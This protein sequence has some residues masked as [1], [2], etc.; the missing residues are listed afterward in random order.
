[1]G[2]NETCV[3]D[4]RHRFVMSYL[5]GQEA[6]SGL[7]DLFGISRPT[8]Y[9]WVERFRHE[10]LSGLLDR[11]S[12][13]LAHGRRTADALRD[14]IVAERHAHPHWGPKKIIG[15][16]CDRQPDVDWP[17]PSTAG[18]ILK[19]EGLV[20][21][22]R[23]RLRVPPR[24][25]ALTVPAHANHVWA[26]DHKGWVRLKDGTRCEP[27]T[28]T[29]GF[30][31][32]LIGLSARPS[33]S[34]A[35]A[36]PLFLQAFEEHGLPETIRTDNGIPFAAPGA[37]GLTELAVLFARLGIRHERIDPGRPQQN[38]RHERFHATLSPAMQPPAAD[39]AEQEAR[40]ERFRA[41]YN[42][43]RPHEALGQRPPARFYV[44]SARPL[45]ERM[46]EPDYPP[47]AAV[48]KVRL[49][50]EIKWA[51]GTIYISTLLTGQPVAIEEGEDGFRVRYFDKPLG[52][53]AKSGSTLQPIRPARQA[54]PKV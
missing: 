24:P 3:M 6:M 47:E 53:I 33:K 54:M 18:L 48:R 21:G 52:T 12:A 8:G 37:T 45:P 16:L 14:A 2:W 42:H 20:P 31:R 50:G 15:K 1:M 10:G 7:C 46:P 44:K 30:S 27:L 25:D 29:D 41:D 40:F 39:V 36:I 49:N 5:S 17:S 23:R 9:K 51:G 28:I 35:L 19:Q 22:R 26:A 13:P 34:N 38:G 32:Y 11:S 4:E 43:D